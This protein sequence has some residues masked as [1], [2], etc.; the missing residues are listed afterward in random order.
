MKITL[1][2]LRMLKKSNIRINKNRN[3]LSFYFFWN[4]KYKLLMKEIMLEKNIII[5]H[6][7]RSKDTV[8]KIPLKN[9]IYT[10]DNS[11]I[12]E[13]ETAATKYKFV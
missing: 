1:R 11:M 6:C 3:S 8:W 2:K 10:I 12:I 9:G 7:P 5:I 13:T 4:S